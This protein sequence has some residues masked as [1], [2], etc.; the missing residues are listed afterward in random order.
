MKTECHKWTNA[1]I[2]QSERQVRE[3]KREREMERMREN[4]GGKERRREGAKG[5]VERWRVESRGSVS[6]C[7]KS[8][9]S[10]CCISKSKME[11]SGS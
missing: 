10:C 7:Q 5:R 9:E 11:T 2:H 3:R 4:E 6:L 8:I 1:A